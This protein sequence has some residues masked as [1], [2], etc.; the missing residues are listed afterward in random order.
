MDWSYIAGFFGGEGCI[1]KRKKEN[2]ITIIITN[3]DIEVLRR[4]K[5]FLSENGCRTKKIKITSQM[6]QLRKKNYRVFRLRIYHHV[7]GLVFCKGILPLVII[8]KTDIEEA[9]NYFEKEVG[10]WRSRVKN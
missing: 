4:I 10:Y 2:G 6:N 5:K 8:K 1:Y 9:K 7:D 3:I